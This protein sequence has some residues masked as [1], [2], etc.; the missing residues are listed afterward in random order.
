MGCARYRRR[1][2]NEQ[3][4]TD[5]SNQGLLD[6]KYARRAL[7][8]NYLPDADANK[9]VEAVRS[10]LTKKL[11]FPAIFGDGHAAEFICSKI[12]SDL[13]KI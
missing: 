2:L 13:S 1:Y 4:D 3:C 9:I 11:N 12:I 10:L 5:N 6:K 7:L 8:V